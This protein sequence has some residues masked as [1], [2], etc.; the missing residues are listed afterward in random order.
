MYIAQQSIASSVVA[1]I[2]VGKTA[3]FASLYN[4]L[5]DVWSQRR[6]DDSRVTSNKCRIELRRKDQAQVFEHKMIG[7]LLRSNAMR[8]NF[9]F[10]QV[11]LKL[12]RIDQIVLN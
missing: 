3:N 2:L 1:T 10:S 11:I 9:V 8:E 6:G 5:C 7:L 4:K 12:Y